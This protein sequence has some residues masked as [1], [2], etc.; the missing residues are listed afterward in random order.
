MNIDGHVALVTGGAS[1]LGAATARHLAGQGARVAVL[2]LGGEAA[3]TLA[4]DIGGLGVQADV[5]DEASVAAALAAVIA[6]FRTGPRVLVNCAGIADAARIVGRE[7]RLSTEIFER[8][9]QVNLIGS[10][11]VMSHA[12]RAM[13]ALEPLGDGARGVII[14]TASIAWQDGQ[15]G[16]A[17][18]AASKGGIAALC[19]PAARE[20][21]GCGIRVM[22]IAPGLFQ[23][24]MMAG[25][26]DDVSA[27]ITANIP[28]PDRLGT[29]QE[30]ALMV[31][32]II[33]NAYLN[34]T[35]IRLDAGVRLPA[36]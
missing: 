6:H 8:V 35:T 10:Y 19:L 29:P 1:G 36:K 13:E 33:E 28:F 12:A 20:L 30:Y 16:Q 23:T 27:K 3:R 25:L 21:A 11:R 15:V 2:D 4:G 31:A 24:P 34:G 22:T 14:N 17:A 26:P 7:G 18:Y 32:Q 5:A 9:I